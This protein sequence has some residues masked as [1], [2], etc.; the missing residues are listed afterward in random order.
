[1]IHKVLRQNAQEYGGFTDL[2]ILGTFR[3]YNAATKTWGSD[4]TGAAD[5]FNTIT[6]TVNADV[7]YNLIQVTE[8]TP[9]TGATQAAVPH[10]VPGYPLAMA[11]I[12]YPFAVSAGTPLLSV[13]V[14]NSLTTSTSILTSSVSDMELQD[15]VILPAAAAV[16]LAPNT[17]TQWLTATVDIAAAG[18]VSVSQLTPK[19]SNPINVGVDI[20]IYV[21]LLPYREWVQNRDA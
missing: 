4:F 1:M 8:T 11:V 3:K 17:V 10:F 9:A 16:P 6:T 12:K 2:F 7:V 14:A 19:A 13:G 18:G 20:W 5:Q 21:T 15:K